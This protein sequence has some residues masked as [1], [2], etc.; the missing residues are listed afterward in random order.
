MTQ[1]TNSCA[2]PF[3]PPSADALSCLHAFIDSIPEPVFPSDDNY[4]LAIDILRATRPLLDDDRDWILPNIALLEGQ[5]PVYDTLIDRLW[6][7]LT[8][9]DA[10]R[11]NIQRVSKEFS[12]T[13]API[14]RLPSDVLRS[15]FGETKSDLNGW[16]SSY[17]R[18]TI[19]F[20]QDTLTLGQVCA[21]WRD[22]VVSSPELWSHI[23]ITFP[24][25]TVDNPGPSPFLKP[26]LTL[27]GQ[28]PLDIRFMLDGDTSSGEAI[29][30]LSSLLRERHRWR[31]ESWHVWSL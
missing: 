13:L 10:Y 6:T 28:H 22:I 15:V 16:G 27:S 12:S 31:M 4:S 17:D 23:K 24:R 21:S 25:L 11:A 2:T 8:A 18:P 7:V 5:L 30:A 3:P 26:T 9:L 29:E 20:M 19:S 14:R 1:E